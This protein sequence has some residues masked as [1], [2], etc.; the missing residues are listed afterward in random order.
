VS[1]PRRIG[2]FVNPCIGSN[3][4]IPPLTHYF[5]GRTGIV[6]WLR[7]F[8]GSLTGLVCGWRRRVDFCDLGGPPA[9]ALIRRRASV[10]H[11]LPCFHRTTTALLL[12]WP[13]SQGGTL[14]LRAVRRN[15]ASSSP[16]PPLMSSCLS[17]SLSDS[18]ESFPGS[19]NTQIGQL[20]QSS[21]NKWSIMNDRFAGNQD[22]SPPPPGSCSDI[23]AYLGE[24]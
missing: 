12:R 2:S 14:D 3:G 23:D 15:H 8:L 1:R 19:Y 24:Y 11:R 9:P 4:L 18:P 16:S 13:C 20:V 17:S 21:S 10:G 22:L 7:K 5:G 6:S